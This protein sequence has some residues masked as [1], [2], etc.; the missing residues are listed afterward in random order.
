MPDCYAPLNELLAQLLRIELQSMCEKLKALVTCADWYL[1]AMKSNPQD[2]T[3]AHLSEIREEALALLA[4]LASRD[5][6]PSTDDLEPA[7]RLE[8]R[9]RYEALC[10]L[11]EFA[12]VLRNPQRVEELHA[13]L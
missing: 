12:F 2:E 10:A 4:V 9:E 11:V 13:A 6:S 7:R 5:K 1:D 8:I 3:L